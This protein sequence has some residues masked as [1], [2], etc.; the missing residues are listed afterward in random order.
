VLT[1]E[2]LRL[3]RASVPIGLWDDKTTHVLTDA[4]REW[5]TPELSQGK[6]AFPTAPS[7]AL[8]EPWKKTALRE[9]P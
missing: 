9:D 8:C 4:D 2:C 7:L 3:S 5:E 6:G 1:D